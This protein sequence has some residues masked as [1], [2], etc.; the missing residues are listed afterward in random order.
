MIWVWSVILV[1]FGG[2]FIVVW[3]FCL[4]CVDE[5]F[6]E[7]FFEQ[8]CGI[9]VWW[10]IE[11]EFD[12]VVCGF[13]LS[14]CRVYGEGLLCIVDVQ[15]R[16]VV[17]E[18]CEVVDFFIDLVFECFD[19]V[20]WMQCFIVGNW[21]GD[22]DFVFVQFVLIVYWVFYLEIVIVV[23]DLCDVV[24]YQMLLGFF[25]GDGR[26]DFVMMVEKEVEGF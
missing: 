13:V 1:L 21:V 19:C 9:V 24:F 20:V 3:M 11:G 14:F 22:G 7:D 12:D 4:G 16:N 26:Y 15:L 8:Y 17:I 2:W 10:Q 25:F 18:K 6:V 23:Y 5:F